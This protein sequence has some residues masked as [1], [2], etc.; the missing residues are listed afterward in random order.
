[1]TCLHGKGLSVLIILA[2]TVAE[3]NYR[4]T[5]PFLTLITYFFFFFSGAVKGTSFFWNNLGLCR[6]LASVCVISC[7]VS[8]LTIGHIA[9]N[10]YVYICH[11][12]KYSKIYSKGRCVVACM[13]SWLLGVAIDLPS[14]LG[15]SQHGFDNKSHKCIFDRKFRYA[16]LAFFCIVGIMLPLVVIII[17]YLKIFI[18]MSA[19]KVKLDKYAHLG[20]HKIFFK[21]LRQARMMFVTF[22]AFS[23][24]WSPYVF[25][26]LLDKDD[27][28]PLEAH[29]I[30]SM[31]A[32]IHAS[33]NFVIYGLHNKTFREAYRIIIVEKIFWCCHNCKAEVK[34]TPSDV[35]SISTCC[36]DVTS[37][38]FEDQHF[39]DGL[40]HCFQSDSR[41][42]PCKEK[43]DDAVTDTKTLTPLSPLYSQNHINGFLANCQSTPRTLPMAEPL[44]AKSAKEMDTSSI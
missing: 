14:H 24:C 8:L 11:H 3:N 35:T 32:H 9:V 16:Y 34:E 39:Q 41:S 40:C 23:F 26:L 20:T 43:C 13:T 33:L 21:T 31:I 42:L 5:K 29:L 44:T 30:T 28:Y 17:F 27:T 4:I 12:S 7:V 19:A 10:R 25:V 37:P 1:M 6:A 18:H 2:P 15:W 36:D 22:V 38:I